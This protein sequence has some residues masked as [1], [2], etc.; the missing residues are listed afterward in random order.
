M[1]LSNSRERSIARVLDFI[2][3]KGVDGSTAQVNLRLNND[4]YLSVKA[5]GPG[6]LASSASAPF[7]DYEVLTDHQTPRFWTRYA[8]LEEGALFAH[9]PAL[10]ITHHIMRFGAGIASA[11]VSVYRNEPVS[12]LSLRLSCPPMMGQAVLAAVSAM[13][14]VSVISASMSPPSDLQLGV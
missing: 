4:T 12:A 2:D 8:E 14:G 9:V 6:V 1:E 5:G 3:I 7:T 10:L 11:E 13:A